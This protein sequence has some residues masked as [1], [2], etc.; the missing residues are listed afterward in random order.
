M[1]AYQAQINRM[2]DIDIDDVDEVPGE[3]EVFS[4][5]YFADYQDGDFEWPEEDEADGS[6]DE[7]DEEHEQ[8]DNSEEFIDV[9]RPA[10]SV[11]AVESPFE[12]EQFPS[13]TAGA[14]IPG[15]ERG[16]SSFEAYHE[17]FGGNDNYSPFNSKLDWDIAQWAKTH[18]ISSSAVTELL[19][20]DGV[21]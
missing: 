14:P 18:N 5:D 3:A 4:G 7:L 21:C 15:S 19:E 11:T 6:D 8:Y 2:N 12:I 10:S 13:R 17:A 1:A 9:V 20:I 16:P